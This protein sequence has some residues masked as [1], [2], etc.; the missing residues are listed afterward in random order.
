MDGLTGSIYPFAY[1]YLLGSF[2]EFALA[3]LEWRFVLDG[4]AL[5]RS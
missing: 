5:I 2:E 4:V 1:F 3:P